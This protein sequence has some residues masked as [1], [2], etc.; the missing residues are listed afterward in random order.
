MG[1]EIEFNKARENARRRDHAQTQLTYDIPDDEW[2]HFDV[3]EKDELTF[4]RIMTD[5]AHY[6]GELVKQNVRRVVLR[7][8]ER[9]AED[10]VAARALLRIAKK[11]DLFS[12]DHTSLSEI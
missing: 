9:K 11:H 10:D 2:S 3:E 4:M 8:L 7:V 1:L 5:G 12:G 6:D